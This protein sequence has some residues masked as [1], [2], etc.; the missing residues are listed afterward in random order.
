[1]ADGIF[2]S[3]FKPDFVST[4]FRKILKCQVSWRSVR[5]KQS[6]S[7]RTDR[8][9]D[10]KTDMT[11]LIQSL[12]AILRTRLKFMRKDYRLC[13]WTRFQSWLLS[14]CTVK[15]VGIRN[16]RLYYWHCESPCF[17]SNKTHRKLYPSHQIWCTDISVQALKICGAQIWIHL[18]LNSVP[19]ALLVFSPL[20]PL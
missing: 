17:L 4:G 9:M 18:L 16:R 6:C 2:N 14:Q 5:W 11:K 7:M 3:A 15:G 8:W 12:F 10:G 19:V 1:M 13:H 20:R